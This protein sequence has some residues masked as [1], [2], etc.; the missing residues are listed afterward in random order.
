MVTSR[1]D[2]VNLQ[3]NLN[4]VANLSRKWLIKLNISKCNVMIINEKQDRVSSKVLLLMEKVFSWK[5]LI[6]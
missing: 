6:I 4:R 2:N 5:G 3:T 1:R